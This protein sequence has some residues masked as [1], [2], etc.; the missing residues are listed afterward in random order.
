[1]T[2]H[3]MIQIFFKNSRVQQPSPQ[4]AMRWWEVGELPNPIMTELKANYEING[5]KRS[6][7]LILI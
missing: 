3:P 7:C 4:V 2:N 6:G 1:M 5:I